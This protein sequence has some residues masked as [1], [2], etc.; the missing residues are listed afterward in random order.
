M[1][2]TSKGCLRSQLISTAL[3]QPYFWPLSQAPA[4]GRL[5]NLQAPQ[6]RPFYSVIPQLSPSALLCAPSRIR[7]YGLRIRPPLVG[8]FHSLRCTPAL[9]EEPSS[10]QLS[11]RKPVHLPLRRCGCWPFS[12]PTHLYFLSC[13]SGSPGETRT[14]IIQLCTTGL[15]DRANTG[16]GAPVALSS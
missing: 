2:F 11:K 14:R 12:C 3:C 9:S 10:P 7:T 1:P 6:A 4:K 16:D 13:F 8:A 5:H 15:E